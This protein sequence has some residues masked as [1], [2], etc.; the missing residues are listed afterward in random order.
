MRALPY[1]KFDTNNWRDRLCIEYIELSQKIEKIEVQLNL[2]VFVEEA[3]KLLF[4]Q[5]HH[6][7]KYREALFKRIYDFQIELYERKPEEQCEP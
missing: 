6:M 2:R 1:R 5:Y 7:L 4:E 3:N